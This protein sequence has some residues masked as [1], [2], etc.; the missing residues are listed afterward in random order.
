MAG[1]NVQNFKSVIDSNQGIMSTN[2]FLVEIA[3][4]RG[5]QNILQ[6]KSEDGSNGTMS[7]YCKSVF[8]PGVGLITTENYRFGYGPLQRK[9]YGTVFNDIMCMFYVDGMQIVRNWFNNWIRLISNP[10]SS[11][12]DAGDEGV[13]MMSKYRGVQNP[14]E[15]SYIDQYAVDMFINVYRDTGELINRVQVGSAYPNFVGDIA[16]DWDAKNS[17]MILPVAFT[18]IDWLEVPMTGKENK[19]PRDLASFVQGATGIDVSAI[20][21]GV[22]T[23]AEVGARV[24]GAEVFRDIAA[25]AQTAIRIGEDRTL[26]RVVQAYDRVTANYGTK[27]VASEPA[28]NPP[29]N[30]ESTGGVGTAPQQTQP[31]PAPPATEM[32]SVA[33]TTVGNNTNSNSVP[34]V[35][36]YV[37]PRD[38]DWVSIDEIPFVEPYNPD[39]YTPRT[40]PQTD[41]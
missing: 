32:G 31:E 34:T 1:F 41:E 39:T 8:L 40:T 25:G 16:L 13:G 33:Q 22:K 17:M 7:F 18:Y 26:G 37:Q 9:P 14:Y 3:V 21:G 20:A 11:F 36:Q 23:I 15:M 27:P 4:P 6:E 12:A 10:T 5:L 24:T 2:K 29:S 30:V 35:P 19:G 28:N 38:P